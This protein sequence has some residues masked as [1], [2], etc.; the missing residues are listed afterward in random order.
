MPPPASSRTRPSS[1]AVLR[2]A[3]PCAWMRARRRCCSR[4]FTALRVATDARRGPPD[5]RP[6]TAAGAPRHRHRIRRCAD[7]PALPRAGCERR[8]A[9]IRDQL[10]FAG[11]GHPF[12]TVPVR[13]RVFGVQ[14]PARDDLAAFRTLFLITAADLHSAVVRRSGRRPRHGSGVTGSPLWLPLGVPPESGR[15]G[16]RDTLAGRIPRPARWSGP[17]A[18]A[19]QRRVA[20]RSGRCG[21]HSAR[22]ARNRLAHG[23]VGP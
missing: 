1:Y 2:G 16:L 10:V 9:S 6:A 22:S 8:P 17:R 19:W 11:N 3:S 5:P 15:M 23:P 14:L 12:A 4:A 18:R 7:R 13:L 21:Y 20:T